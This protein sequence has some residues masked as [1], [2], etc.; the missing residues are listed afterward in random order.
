MFIGGGNRLAAA[1]DSRG[2]RGVRPVMQ[3]SFPAAAVPRGQQKFAC[4]SIL[5]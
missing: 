5:Q 1:V 3:L 4:F 2:F